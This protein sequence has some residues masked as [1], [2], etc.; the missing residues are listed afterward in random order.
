[1]A[2]LYGSEM[3]R[4]LGVAVNPTARLCGEIVGAAMRREVGVGG[5]VV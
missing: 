5:G 4:V 1:M 3:G 2:G